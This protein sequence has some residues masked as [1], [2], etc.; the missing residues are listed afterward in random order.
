M[1]SIAAT[2]GLSDRFA[3]SVI[4][5]AVL[6]MT[7]SL[8]KDCFSLNIRCNSISPV[9][10]HAPF[11][12]AFREKED[13][14]E[15]KETEYWEAVQNFQKGAAI[16]ARTNGLSPKRLAEAVHRPLTTA[17][18]HDACRR[19]P[20][21]GLHAA[22]EDRGSQVSIGANLSKSKAA[23][24]GRCSRYDWRPH[25]RRQ[26]T[27]EHRIHED[28]GTCFWPISLKL[29]SQSGSLLLALHDRQLHV[30][31]RHVRTYFHSVQGQPSVRS[32]REECRWYPRRPPS[33]LHQRQA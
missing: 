20:K 19:S 15:F 32:K 10:V 12:D 27:R 31:S 24:A 29:A 4:K 8:V 18:P 16:E 26:Q 1:D 9:R 14:I 22:A 21:R 23:D 3:Y 25:Y 7:L 30:E 28:V 33:N 6:A 11:V 17:R 5:G 13:L 2:C